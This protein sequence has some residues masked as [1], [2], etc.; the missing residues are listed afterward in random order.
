MLNFNQLH[1]L[2]IAIE[3]NYNLSDFL[4]EKFIIYIPDFNP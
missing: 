1:K 4:P 3:I 2:K